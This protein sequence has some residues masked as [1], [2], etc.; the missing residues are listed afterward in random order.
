MSQLLAN[1]A[2]LIPT[3]HGWCSVPKAITLASSVIAL[4]PAVSVEIG[5]Y[6]GRSFLPI[7]MAHKEIGIGMAYGID[8]WSA[9]ESEIGQVHPSDRD[10]WSKLD[11][12]IIYQHFSKS[13][14]ECGAASCAKILRQCSDD[15][16]VPDQIDLFHLDGNHSDQAVKDVEK[17][18]PKIRV[19]GL[20]FMDDIHWSGGGVERATAKLKSMGFIRLYDLDSGA[21]FQRVSR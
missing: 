16:D 17:F 12:E 5:V 13:L 18:A 21:V 10:Y 15:A 6:G 4:R 20:A 1:I 14:V 11:H 19:G 7:A 9:R 8:P 3:L 2:T